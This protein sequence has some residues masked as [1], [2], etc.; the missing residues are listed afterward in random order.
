MLKRLCVSKLKGSSPEINDCQCCW[1][2]CYYRYRHRCCGCLGRFPR[3]HSH[4]QLLFVSSSRDLGYFRLD[5][6]LVGQSR[7]AAERSR[8]EKDKIPWSIEWWIDRLSYLLTLSIIMGSRDE[9]LASHTCCLAYDSG[10]VPYVGW[11]CCSF[12]PYS[13]GF[14]PVLRFSSLAPPNFNSNRI[15]PAGKSAEVDVACLQILLFISL[16]I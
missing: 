7:P 5:L 8:K 16:F 13:E 10:P 3:Q 2:C 6:V 4:P 12:P 11:V 9:A 1:Y 14:S 15:E